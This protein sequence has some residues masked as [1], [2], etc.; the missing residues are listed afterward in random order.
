MPRQISYLAPKTTLS[1]VGLST[2]CRPGV[3]DHPRCRGSDSL[4]SPDLLWVAR[5]RPPSPRCTLESEE[6]SSN[7]T[8][9]S[10]P[11]RKGSHPDH[12]LF[13]H[14]LPRFV[15]LTSSSTFGHGRG[16]SRCEV[17]VRSKSGTLDDPPETPVASG[18]DEAI[19]RSQDERVLLDEGSPTALFTQH[20]D[21][22]VRKE[23]TGS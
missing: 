19:N 20:V 1:C 9:V 4:V 6:V 12:R 7:D 10:S 15:S 2:G 14:H 17:R 8:P 3:P 22:R 21:R 5:L 23:T 13:I 16:S 11:S 18:P